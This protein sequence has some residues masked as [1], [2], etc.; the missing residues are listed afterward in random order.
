MEA[1]KKDLSLPLPLA[2]A[3]SLSFHGVCRH[4][5]LSWSLEQATPKRATLFP[6][7]N[8][9]GTSVE[10]GGGNCHLST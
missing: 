7:F 5:P 6:D 3:L 4:Q 2:L 10:K 1:F 8:R 9:S